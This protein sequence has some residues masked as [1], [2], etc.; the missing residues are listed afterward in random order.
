[1][2]VEQ[3]EPGQQNKEGIFTQLLVRLEVKPLHELD[4]GFTSNLTDY[5]D[6]SPW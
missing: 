2:S 4:R 3:H 1:M 5:L 6:K